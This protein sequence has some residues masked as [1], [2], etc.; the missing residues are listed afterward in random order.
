M[1]AGNAH[2]PLE[3]LT[4]APDVI[5]TGIYENDHR[6]IMSL[7]EIV[8]SKPAGKAVEIIFRKNDGSLSSQILYEKDLPGIQVVDNTLRLRNPSNQRFALAPVKFTTT[9]KL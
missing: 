6:F 7:V 2:R 4:F 1:S 5:V 3:Y 9:E 8:S